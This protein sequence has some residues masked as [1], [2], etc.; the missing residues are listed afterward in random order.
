VAASISDL[1][2]NGEGVDLF[3][4]D[5][6]KTAHEIRTATTKTRGTDLSD[7]NP[8]KSYPVPKRMAY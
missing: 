2:G 1:V 7:P 5:A 8:T 6:G 3:L 4:A